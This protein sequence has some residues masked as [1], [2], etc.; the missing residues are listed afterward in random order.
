VRDLVRVR[1][2]IAFALLVCFACKQEEKPVRHDDELKRTLASM[3]AAIAAF[4]KNNGRYPSTLNELVPK[5][6]PRV[7][8][9]PVTNSAA[10][11]QP[12]TEDT[13]QPNS[14]FTTAKS[15]QPRSVIIDVRSGAGA[16]YSTY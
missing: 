14:D 12:V 8:V 2:L 11:W 13:V 16:P 6:L 15:E 1:A 7:P 9:D 10:T 3:R 4:Q 5:Y